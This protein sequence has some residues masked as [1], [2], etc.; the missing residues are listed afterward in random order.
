VVVAFEEDFLHT[1]EPEALVATLEAYV[2]DYEK[3][4]CVSRKR[5]KKAAIPESGCVYNLEKKGGVEGKEALQVDCIHTAALQDGEEALE[6]PLS[7]FSEGCTY[8]EN[9]VKE[10]V[11]V[12]SHRKSPL[13]AVLRV[14]QEA[15]LAYDSNNLFF[16]ELKAVLLKNEEGC[17][18]NR[19]LVGAEAN[20]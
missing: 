11:C 15:W 10:E 12:A 19:A 18:R 5:A 8:E 14:T 16:E 1:K 3:L 4:E 9:W 2:A 7:D 17:C 13:Q 20:R 6:E